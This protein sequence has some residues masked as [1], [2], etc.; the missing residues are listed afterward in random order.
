MNNA[1]VRYRKNIV[2]FIPIL[3]INT[4]NCLSKR[5]KAGKMTHTYQ[6]APQKMFQNIYFTT[7]NAITYHFFSLS[8]VTMLK[9]NY[10]FS[11]I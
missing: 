10:Y 3:I 8:D 11:Y 4:L 5:L 7:A 9:Q 6:K 2:Y 1:V